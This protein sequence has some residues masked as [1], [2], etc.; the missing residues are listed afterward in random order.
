MVLNAQVSNS[1]L[2]FRLCKLS[3]DA[4]GTPVVESD[5]DYFPARSNF[6]HFSSIT[7]RDEHRVLT[8]YGIEFHHWIRIL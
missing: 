5:N 6:T 1:L 2:T 3:T 4:V 8:M 7:E